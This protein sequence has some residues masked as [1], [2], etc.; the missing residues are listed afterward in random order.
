MGQNQYHGPNA[1]MFPLQSARNHN[2][3]H[4]PTSCTTPHHHIQIQSQQNTQHA[5]CHYTP[6]TTKTRASSV[7]SDSAGH[8]E[9][10]VFDGIWGAGSGQEAE[11]VSKTKARHTGCNHK[12][13]QPIRKEQRCCVLRKLRVINSGSLTNKQVV[14]GVINQKTG[15]EKRTMTP[16]FHFAH[17]LSLRPWWR[18]LQFGVV[19]PPETWAAQAARGEKYTCVFSACWFWQPTNQ[20]EIACSLAFSPSIADYWDFYFLNK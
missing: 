15:G 14:P 16:P 13:A 6:R 17:P 9:L 12:T 3:P 10:P 20:F 18:I 2:A 5:C 11:L 19:G 7:C 4:Q 8:G 1:C